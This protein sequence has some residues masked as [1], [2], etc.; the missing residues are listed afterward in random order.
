MLPPPGWECSTWKFSSPNPKYWHWTGGK[1]KE[2]DLD[3][4]AVLLPSQD[5]RK[6]GILN[7]F[8]RF[9]MGSVFNFLGVLSRV[10]EYLSHWMQNEA[11]TCSFTHS[12]FHPE[13][14]TP[15]Y[16]RH[17]ESSAWFHPE[18]LTLLVLAVV[19]CLIWRFLWKK[20]LKADVPT[21]EF[22]SCSSVLWHCLKKGPLD[23]VSTSA[24]SP[25]WWGGGRA[26]NFQANWHAN[27]LNTPFV[28][29]ESWS[30]SQP[31][32]VNLLS[33]ST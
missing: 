22:V 13:I 12:E 1:S 23:I 11:Y 33:I 30:V 17:S 16:I 8:F 20:R 15:S 27:D 32:K 26:L 3:L 5:A 2:P 9:V 4:T 29:T 21:T 24:N 14:S 10:V 18:I 19:N 7:I 31:K 6:T 25:F 28:I